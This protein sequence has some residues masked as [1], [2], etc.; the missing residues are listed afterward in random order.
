MIDREVYMFWYT[1]LITAASGV[2]FY[3]GVSTVKV[4]IFVSM[5]KILALALI[6]GILIYFIKWIMERK[7]PRQLP[8]PTDS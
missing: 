6:A 7:K 8:K 2:L 4:S 3:F 1:L 5:F